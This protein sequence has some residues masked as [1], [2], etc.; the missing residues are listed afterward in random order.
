MNRSQF[1]Q[2]ID[3]WK[4][5]ESTPEDEK[6]LMDLFNKNESSVKDWMMTELES[7]TLD[8]DTDNVDFD[9]MFKYIRAI[10]LHKDKRR[11]EGIIKRKRILFVKI[12]AAV[13]TALFTG[14]IVSYIFF[15][16]K[17]HSASNSFAE[18]KTPNGG[19][20][21]IT[22]PDG[23]KV[24]LNAGSSIRYENGF[25]I[26]N[27]NIYLEGEGY[28]K[29]AKN[30]QLPFV[31]NTTEIKIRAVGTEFNVKAY[32]RDNTIE[33]TLIEGKISI[34]GTKKV[35][36]SVKVCLGQNEKAVYI[37]NSGKIDINALKNMA[38][39]Q[40][41]QPISTAQNILVSEKK[42]DPNPDIAWLENKLI[43]KRDDL[44]K[45]AITLERKYNVTIRFDSEDVKKFKFTGTL[46]DVSL[47]QVLDVIKLTSPIDYSI[48]GKEV[49][50]YENK[51]AQNEFAKHLRK[52]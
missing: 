50:I 35:N 21:E 37:K 14:G 41:L 28:F 31:V 20:S 17:M 23:S 38:V 19:R 6:L 10:I 29:V 34:E 48:A 36:T 11:A 8:Q 7:L 44:E 43:F 5:K 1:H 40:H 15:S 30:K 2:L 33:T 46:D 13:V 4:K 52:R 27:R 45:I 25:N 26:R 49:V 22:L 3:K 9:V 47:Q 12:A 39:L 18:I 51:V 16:S 42:I 24:W 32:S